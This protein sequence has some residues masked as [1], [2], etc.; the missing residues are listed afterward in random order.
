M[1]Q[2]TTK[3]EVD[4][5]ICI[6]IQN[7]WEHVSNIFES[8]ISIKYIKYQISFGVNKKKKKNKERLLLVTCSDAF[9]LLAKL[10]RKLVDNNL[11]LKKK[12]MIN[13][14]NYLYT[15]NLWQWWKNLILTT[16]YHMLTDINTHTMYSI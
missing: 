10:L 14:K 1:I 7:Y 4:N 15:K 3:R 5:K 16:V 13:I 12:L 11:W 6:K 2:Y 9:L 8:I